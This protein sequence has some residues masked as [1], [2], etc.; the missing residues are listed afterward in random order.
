MKKALELEL[1]LCQKKYLF[2][3]IAAFVLDNAIASF[4]FLIFYQNNLTYQSSRSVIERYLSFYKIME[5]WELKA[6]IYVECKIIIYQWK[7]LQLRMSEQL[8]KL[9]KACSALRANTK[10][11][12]CCFS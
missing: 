8:C 11:S 2:Y 10:P 1:Q 3:N 5:T 6:K 12:Q 9:C 4:I 7:I